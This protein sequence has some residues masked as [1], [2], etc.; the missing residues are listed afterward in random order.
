MSCSVI[1]PTCLFC[2]QI[3]VLISFFDLLLMAFKEHG[4]N[5]HNLLRRRGICE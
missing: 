2:T 4:K 3:I 5:K 1:S